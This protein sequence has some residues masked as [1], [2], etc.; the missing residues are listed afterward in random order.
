MVMGK[1]WRAPIQ[2]NWSLTFRRRDILV[3][4]SKNTAIVNLA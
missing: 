4:G 1:L 3:G 2:S